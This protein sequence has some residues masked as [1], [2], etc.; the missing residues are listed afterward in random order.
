ML[1]GEFGTAPY[2]HLLRYDLYDGTDAVGEV[3]YLGGLH[4][5]GGYVFEVTREVTDPASGTVQT[6]ENYSELGWLL[7]TVTVLT[8]AVPLVTILVVNRT[9]LR[10]SD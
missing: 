4:A 1:E 5:E 3:F 10:S 8:V 9:R 6:A 7:I 2:A